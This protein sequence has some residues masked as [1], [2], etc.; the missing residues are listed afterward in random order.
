MKNEILL[1]TQTVVELENIQYDTLRMRI[2]RGRI[3]A[4]RIEI[5]NKQGFE[6]RIPLSELSYQA[7]QKYIVKMKRDSPADPL[8]AQDRKGSQYENLTLKDLTEEQRAEVYL[9][10]EILKQRQK[11]VS[12]NPGKQMEKTR[13]LIKKLKE[14]HPQLRISERTLSRKW[15]KYKKYGEVG[16]SDLRKQPTTNR[17]KEISETVAA[18]FGQYWLS[19]NR[20]AVTLAYRLTEEWAKDKRPDLLPLPCLRTF[21]RMV[22]K[23]PEH[24]IKYF[25][26]GQKVFED[27]C[28]PYIVREYE[29]LA[30]NEV[31]SADYHTLDVMVKDDKTDELFR[32]HLIYW[33]DVRSRKVLSFYLAK[34]SNSDGTF[35]SFRNAVLKYGIP[36]NVYLDNGREFLVSDIGG[37]GRRKTDKTADYGTTLFKR[38]GIEM[39]NATVKNGKAKIIERMFLN[40]KNDFSK[41]LNTYT[42]GKPEE[43]PESYKTIIKNTNNIKNF[44]EIKEA[45]KLYIEGIYN[46]KSSMAKGLNGLCP[47]EFYTRNFIQKKALTHEQEELLLLRTQRLQKVKRNGVKF[48]FENEELWYYNTD[49][50]INYLGLDVYLRYNPENMNTVQI[51][52]DSERFICTAE[53][54]KKGGYN[55]GTDIDKEVIKENNSRKKKLKNNAESFMN[56]LKDIQQ[57]PEALEVMKAAARRNIK[58]NK[59]QYSPKILEPL[60]FSV[61]SL[62]DKEDCDETVNISMETMIKNAQQRRAENE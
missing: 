34:T 47:E 23:Y 57:A 10:K 13:E 6:Y 28:M 35:I 49:L 54:T 17:P 4:F 26:D 41:L 61:S 59:Y 40:V 27:E 30:V 60:A 36:E 31:W 52:D 8:P 11:I 56:N 37:R 9:W 44:S 2:Q 33:I 48:T 55:L 14:E 5:G 15:E 12:E 50:I 3:K 32:P 7:Q 16:L 39:T 18:V 53:L 43:R 62:A 1:N 22:E 46:K 20:P 51:Y 42:G 24:I 19:E 25:R 45:V 38:L 21:Y 29:N 58:E